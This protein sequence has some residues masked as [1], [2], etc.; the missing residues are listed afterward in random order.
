MTMIFCVALATLGSCA[1]E[2]EI[3]MVEEAAVPEETNGYLEIATEEP[4]RVTVIGHPEIV[5][6]RPFPGRVLLNKSQFQ[7]FVQALAAETRGSR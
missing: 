5:A 4:I 7:R 2:K 3:V 6:E 1:T